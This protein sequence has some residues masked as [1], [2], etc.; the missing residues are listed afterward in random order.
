VEKYVRKN[1]PTHLLH[2][3]WLTA[4]GIF[5]ESPEN[6]RWVEATLRL[7]RAFV[8]H[9][10]KRF[11]GVGTCFEVCEQES[12]YGS[13]K[14]VTRKLIEDYT[15]RVGIDFAWGRLFHLYGPYERP[16]RLVPQVI[17]GLLRGIPVK[18]SSGEQLRDYLYVQDCADMLVSLLDADHQGTYEI[19]SGVALKLGDLIKLFADA[20]GKP[21]LIELG[22]VPDRLAEP[23]SILPE[24]K[25]LWL[26]KISLK[27]GIFKTIA[28][29]SK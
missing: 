4:P 13:C 27:E 16:E 9:G 11:V 28:Y 26:P 14:E 10:G 18:C 8:E 25:I 6:F 24:N 7:C 21:H 3:A 29:W 22:A 15:A 12:F 23:K 1:Q 2:L 20:L 5:F 17:L 19:A